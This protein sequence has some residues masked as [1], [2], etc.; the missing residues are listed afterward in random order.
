MKKHKTLILAA[1]FVFAMI[2]S[3]AACGGGDTAP[4]ATPEPVAEATP[5]PT[6]E[7]TPAPT[8]EP[9]PEPKVVVRGNVEDGKYISEYL[10]FVLDFESGGFSFHRDNEVNAYEFLEEIPESFWEMMITIYEF[11]V[12]SQ[13]TGV[14]IGIIFRKPANYETSTFDEV[15]FISRRPTSN[16]SGTNTLDYEFD[17]NQKP[18]TIG[19]SDWYFYVEEVTG[20]TQSY[21]VHYISF[22][23]EILRNI[24]LRG[25]VEQ[26]DQF[27]L[28]SLITPYP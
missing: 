17:P 4:A 10:G 13:S 18:V 20:D 12:Y 27:D 9:E 28:L 8:P 15:D 25:T 23:G 7:P 21:M 5:A 14:G 6:P 11:N 3:L 1:I 26:L 24:Y 16:F 22:N 2:F 19:D